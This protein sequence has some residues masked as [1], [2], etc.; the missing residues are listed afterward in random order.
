[1]PPTFLY[2]LSLLLTVE[3]SISNEICNISQLYHCGPWTG[4]GMESS[5]QNMVGNLGRFNVPRDRA[6]TPLWFLSSKPDDPKSFA[7]HK[8]EATTVGIAGAVPPSSPLRLTWF[9]PSAGGSAAGTAVR[10]ICL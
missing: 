7:V 1:M 5:F 6:L 3:N 4:A 2:L 9:Q 10:C 8:P